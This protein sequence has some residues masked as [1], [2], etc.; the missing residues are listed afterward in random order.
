[1]ATCPRCDIPL[2]ATTYAGVDIESCTRCGGRWLDPDSL[3][4]IVDTPEP[5]PSGGQPGTTDRA[6]TSD[7]CGLTRLLDRRS[8]RS[9]RARSNLPRSDQ[10]TA[11]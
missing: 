7:H 8:T 10:A 6:R 1:M 11:T 4:A 9:K 3:K 5:A 2:E